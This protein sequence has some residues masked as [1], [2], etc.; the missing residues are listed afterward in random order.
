MKHVHETTTPLV[1]SARV[2]QSPQ[3]LPCCWEK[4][5]DNIF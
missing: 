4:T 1:N 3:L 5:V 2:G